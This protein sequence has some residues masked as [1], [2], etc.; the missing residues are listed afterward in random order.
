MYIYVKTVEKVVQDVHLLYFR[1]IDCS[2]HVP[3]LFKIPIISISPFTN[4][5]H[6]V[7]CNY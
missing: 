6:H 5:S 7:I 4:W 2:E 3:K 1:H